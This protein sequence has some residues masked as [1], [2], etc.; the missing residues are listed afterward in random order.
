M[1][2]VK[3]YYCHQVAYVISAKE[4]LVTSGVHEAANGRTNFVSRRDV[5]S[6]EV[7]A[8]ESHCEQKTR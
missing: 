6:V 4:L 5:E 7:A 2:R 3:L 8:I 1:L